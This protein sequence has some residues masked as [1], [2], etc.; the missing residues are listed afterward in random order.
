MFND[1]FER[2]QHAGVDARWWSFSTATADVPAADAEPYAATADPRRRRASCRAAR[3]RDVQPS[4]ID[5]E[6]VLSAIRDNF[7]SLPYVSGD[8][9]DPRLL[10]ARRQGD[11]LHADRAA[12]AAAPARPLRAGVV[13]PD[14][15]TTSQNKRSLA[16][17]TIVGAYFVRGDRNETHTLLDLAVVDPEERV[18][19]AA[20]GRHELARRQHDR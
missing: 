11:G 7:K 12:V 5:R 13:R 10:P 4:A 6:K 8:R 9:P 15:T 3:H 14:R 20:L 2:R 1:W 16:Y 19:G 17:L 18:A